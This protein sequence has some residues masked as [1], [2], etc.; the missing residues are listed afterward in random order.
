MRLVVETVTRSERSRPL[1][2]S[3]AAK[4]DSVL[5]IRESVPLVD[6]DSSEFEAVWAEPSGSE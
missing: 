3:K 2:I 5:D 6:H 1:N 4:S